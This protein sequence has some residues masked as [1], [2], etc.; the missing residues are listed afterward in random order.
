MLARLGGDI[1]DRVTAISSRKAFCGELLGAQILRHPRLLPRFSSV[2]L[3]AAMCVQSPV[4][5]VSTKAFRS[6]FL[7]LCG[8]IFPVVCFVERTLT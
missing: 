3:S 6:L 1:A 7:C 5:Q 2:R 4:V 8:F